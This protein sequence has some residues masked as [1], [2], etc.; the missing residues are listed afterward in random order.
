MP[1]EQVEEYVEAI[2]DIAGEKGTA[3][4]MEV[5]NRLDNAPASV[6]EVF[7]NMARKGLV[8]YAPYKGVSLTDKGLEIAKKIKRKHRLLEVF[9]TNTLHINCKKVH[10]EA[11]KME[12]AVSDEIGNALCRRLDAPSRCPGGKL[13]YPC[14]KSIETCN[15]CETPLDERTPPSHRNIVP[16]TDLKPSQKGIVAFLRGGK[17]VIQRLSD[18]GLTPDTEVTL[19]RKAPMGGPIELLARRTNLAV[20]RDIADNIFVKAVGSD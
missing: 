2:F 11:C 7:Q 3:K 5:A 9:L 13:I 17:K 14:E 12:H 8:E 15:E 4:T 19:V 1:Q 18:L 20:G 10:D 6:T 16:I